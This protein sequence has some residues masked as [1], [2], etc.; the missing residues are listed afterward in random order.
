MTFFKYFALINRF[1]KT[2]ENLAVEK[3][4]SN[5][6]S[7]GTEPKHIPSNIRHLFIQMELCSGTLR[8]VHCE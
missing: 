5:N 2:F 8:F 7:K 1:I 4:K 6:Y 3:S